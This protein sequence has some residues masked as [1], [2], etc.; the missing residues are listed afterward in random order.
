MKRIGSR[1]DESWQMPLRA[2]R[3]SLNDLVEERGEGG[4]ELNAIYLDS[5]RRL[6]AVVII[7]RCN[8]IFSFVSYYVQRWIDDVT[9]RRG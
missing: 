2:A 7:F 3:R 6:R 5:A 1:H 4:I 8:S 9:G